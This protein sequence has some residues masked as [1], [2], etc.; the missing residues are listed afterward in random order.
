MHGGRD[1]CL[2]TDGREELFLAPCAEGRG[3]QRWNF[4]EAVDGKRLRE[5]DLNKL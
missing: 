3:G 5:W 4:T 1:L 2:E